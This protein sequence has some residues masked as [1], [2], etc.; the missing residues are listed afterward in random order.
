MNQTLAIQFE[1]LVK[2]KLSSPFSPE[3]GEWPP[4]PDR[5]F[6]AL[7]ATAA[8]TNQDMNVL[9]ALEFPPEILASS[10]SCEKAPLRYVPENFRRSNAYHQGASRYLPT[11][12]PQNPV[13][14]YFWNNI[15]HNN[16]EKIVAIAEN[17]THL[18]RASSLVHVRAVSA[19]GLAPN[20]FPDPNG[21]DALRAPTKGRLSLL[22]EAF[23]HHLRSPQA[24]VIS[25]SNSDIKYSN[26]RWKELM[27]LRPSNGINGRF[28]TRWAERIRSSIMSYMDPNIL[29]IVSGH[30]SDGSINHRHVAWA[31]IP[32]I[33]HK[34]SNG[35]ILGLGCWLPHN[36]TDEECGELWSALTQITATDGECLDYDDNDLKSLRIKTWSRP[37][38][39][40]AT[41]TPIALDRWPK[42]NHPAEK[43]IADSIQR[44][45]LPNPKSITCSSFSEFQGAIDTT[46]YETRKRNR[47]LV[48]ARIE[49][50]EHIGGPLLIG[51]ERYFG[52]GLCR[53]IIE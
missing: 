40:W 44:L 24:S 12:H 3:W 1:F 48:H 26:E 2:P 28:A 22:Q 43:I 33:G 29:S 45:G 9:T 6:Q 17:I 13:V 50:D 47:Q 25:Y 15:A 52:G 42:K 23:N 46:R 38:K 30:N 4:A 34:Y 37:S 51:A 32:N 53:P 10:A 27:V 5:V 16:Y 39:C 19:D 41:V 18:G 35:S 21:N 7:V 36:I 49:W 20:W 31:A 11:V 14:T 8:E